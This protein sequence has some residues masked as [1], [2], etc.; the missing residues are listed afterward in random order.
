MLHSASSVLLHS[1][2]FYVPFLICKNPQRFNGG[3]RDV[4]VR[5]VLS[6]L[7]YR[8][9]AAATDDEEELNATSSC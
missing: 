6:P 7:L 1:K 2:M 4:E 9:S 3:N 8:P 5:T